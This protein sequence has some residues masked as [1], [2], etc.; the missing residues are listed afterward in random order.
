MIPA[1]AVLLSGRAAAVLKALETDSAP[2]S[3]A[4]ARRARALKPVLLV[5]CLHGEVVR[6]SL[7]PKNLRAGYDLGNLYVE[8]LPSFWSLSYTIVK[9]GGQRVM[10]VIEIKNHKEYSRWFPGRRRWPFQASPVRRAGSINGR[11]T[12]I[13]A[14]LLPV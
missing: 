8:D 3:R 13:G 2:A 4:I 7:I 12:L 5:D 6:S 11:D 10:V 9:R 1:S 14:R